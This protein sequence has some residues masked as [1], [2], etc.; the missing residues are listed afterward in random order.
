V[1]HVPAIDRLAALGCEELKTWGEQDAL[2]HF[3]QP[4]DSI[5]NKQPRKTIE[6]QVNMQCHSLILVFKFP[7][8]Q[9]TEP[10]PVACGI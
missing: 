9:H 8:Q 5:R 2:S 1:F 7:E 6:M 4:G 3:A 10:A